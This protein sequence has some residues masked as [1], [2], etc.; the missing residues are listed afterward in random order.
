VF[1]V[2]TTIHSFAAST[3]WSHSVEPGT[4]S[5]RS[6]TGTGGCANPPPTL[7]IVEMSEMPAVV[8]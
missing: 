8:I 5:I 6:N 1:I 3:C 7:V 4:G 2:L